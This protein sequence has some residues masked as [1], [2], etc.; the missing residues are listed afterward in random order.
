MEREPAR[1]SGAN[2]R[3]QP[4]HSGDLLISDE[5]VRELKR[6]ALEG[7]VLCALEH[8]DEEDWD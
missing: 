2:Q 8:L 7:C 1:S 3:L 6:Q 4:A 5:A